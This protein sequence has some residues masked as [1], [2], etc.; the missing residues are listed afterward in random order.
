M[1]KDAVTGFMQLWLVR[2]AAVTQSQ[3]EQCV[4]T[5][6]T[7]SILGTSHMAYW[8]DTTESCPVAVELLRTLPEWKLMEV[9]SKTCSP[10]GTSSRLSLQCSSFPSLPK[11]LPCLSSN[12]KAQSITHIIA[13]TE[14]YLMRSPHT[15]LLMCPLENCTHRLLKLSYCLVSYEG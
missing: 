15:L 13:L 1:G 9:S 11:A 4:H 6:G 5:V 3:D 14:D 7:P 10:L 8:P 2:G 12:Q